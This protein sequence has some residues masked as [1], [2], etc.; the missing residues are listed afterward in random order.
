MM[1]NSHASIPAGVVEVAGSFHTKW[2][3]AK[4]DFHINGGTG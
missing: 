2:P 1:E 4:K 3:F